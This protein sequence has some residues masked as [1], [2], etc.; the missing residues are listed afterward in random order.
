MSAARAAAGWPVESA[1]LSVRPVVVVNV[2]GPG[3]EP[4]PVPAAGL[5]DGEPLMLGL[6]KPAIAPMSLP[7]LGPPAPGSG[8]ETTEASAPSWDR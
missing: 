8:L 5:A 3:H 2:D 6:P 1:A 7:A 4:S